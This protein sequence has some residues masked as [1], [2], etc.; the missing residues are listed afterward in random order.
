MKDKIKE[1]IKIIVTAIVIAGAVSI[2]VQPVL[3]D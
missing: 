3:V 1:W 2:F